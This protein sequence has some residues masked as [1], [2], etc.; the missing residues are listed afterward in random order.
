MWTVCKLRTSN[1]EILQPLDRYQ[2]FDFWT[3]P[4]IYT[5]SYHIVRSNSSNLLIL[6]PFSSAPI[7]Y[8]T[9]WK[10]RKPEFWLYQH[11]NI[12]KLYFIEILLNLDFIAHKIRSNSSNLIILIWY[13][14]G[15]IQNWTICRIKIIKFELLQPLNWVK[16]FLSFSKSSSI[17][18]SHKIAYKTRNLIIWIW[19]RVGVISHW[20]IF[21]KR[22]PQFYG[23]V[24][25]RLNYGK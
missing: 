13:S 7:S 14:K 6:I 19:F 12:I 11:L 20:S 21:H 2:V 18:F 23:I 25:S 4:F 8:K 3:L 16:V 17:V 5:Y 22:N 24:T 1:F 10:E 9:I 15:K